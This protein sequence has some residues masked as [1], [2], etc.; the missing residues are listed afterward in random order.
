LAGLVLHPVDDAADVVAGGDGVNAPVAVHQGDRGVLEHREQG[1][2][3]LHDLLPRLLTAVLGLQLPRDV[4]E[5]LSQ[6]GFSVS[7]V[8]HRRTFPSARDC[9][10]VR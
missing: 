9:Q 5:R 3:H 1:A 10:S 7:A 2:G 8:H 6:L 4:G